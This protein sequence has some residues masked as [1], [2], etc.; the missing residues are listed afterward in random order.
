[1]RERIIQTVVQHP[2]TILLV[3]LLLILLFVA[4]EPGAAAVHECV[5][6]NAGDPAGL[7]ENCSGPVS[8]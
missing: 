5:L 6:E 2:K 8:P 1:M 7:R 4:V 3:V